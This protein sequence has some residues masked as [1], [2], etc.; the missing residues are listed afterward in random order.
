[1]FQIII[2]KLIQIDKVSF[3]T[4]KSI[5]KVYINI[6]ILFQYSS[7]LFVLRGGQFLQYCLFPKIAIL[8]S[9]QLSLHIWHHRHLQGWSQCVDCLL[10]FKDLLLID[11]LWLVEL[12][13]LLLLSLNLA[14]LGLLGLCE[15]NEDTYLAVLEGNELAL[16][17][18]ASH[19]L[20]DLGLWGL[21]LSWD[22]LAALALGLSQN[23]SLLLLL[24]VAASIEIS[25]NTAGISNNHTNISDSI[26]YGIHQQPQYPLVPRSYLQY[27]SQQ[28]LSQESQSEYYVIMKWKLNQIVINCILFY[29][30]QEN[31]MITHFCDIII[32]LIGLDLL[33]LIL[34]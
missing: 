23:Y 31:T 26:S 5:R 22:N 6:F 9:L 11:W 34:V 21:G 25:T 3:Q 15:W 27:P 1:M 19:V 8:T 32:D 28:L 17:G 4:L 12:R 33:N 7:L 13:S 24:L 30:Q 2:N 14:N 29:Q 10:D 20:V 18:Y 16:W